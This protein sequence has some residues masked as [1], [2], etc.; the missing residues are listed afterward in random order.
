MHTLRKVAIHRI[1]P[2]SAFRTGLALS[3]AG[4]AAWILCVIILYFAL[5]SAG[6]WAKLNE[7]IGGAGGDEIVTFGTVLSIASLLGSLAA[8]VTTVLA[9]LIAVIYN[10]LVELFGGITLH[11]DMLD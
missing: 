6:I 1:S 3:L 9:P 8:I 2:L 7:V 11:V 10:G 5:D 4:L